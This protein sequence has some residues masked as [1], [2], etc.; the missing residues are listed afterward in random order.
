MVKCDLSLVGDAG[1]SQIPLSMYTCVYAFVLG[2]YV[3]MSV[4]MCI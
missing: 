3:Y 4:H 2:A 1:G